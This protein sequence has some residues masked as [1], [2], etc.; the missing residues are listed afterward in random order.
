MK[1]TTEKK[2]NTVVHWKKIS[3]ALSFMLFVAVS[4]VSATTDP[5]V[6]EK[7]D[8]AFKKEFSGAKLIR[9]TNLGEFLKAT[10]ILGNH[11][12]EAY[13]SPDGQLEGSMRTLFYSQL[14][15]VVMT[16]VDKKFVNADIWD[17]TE[18]NNANGTT[19]RIT[20]EQKNR[21]YRVRVDANGNFKDIE[22]LKK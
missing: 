22:K 15:L 10:F 8:A 7:V 3:L 2:L 14:P 17:V 13:F 20:L 4:N 16:S 11:R 21:K 5:T 18:I 1:R 12:T 19:Y 6:N 9:W